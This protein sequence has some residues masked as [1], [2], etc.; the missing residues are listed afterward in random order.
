ML[1]HCEGGPHQY[2]P[3]W[4]GK[5]KDELGNAINPEANELA[6]GWWVSNPSIEDFHIQWLETEETKAEYRKQYLAD[7]ILRDERV[8][9]QKLADLMMYVDDHIIRSIN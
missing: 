4:C 6:K 7:W 3:L 8:S 5:G 9:D 2:D 1:C